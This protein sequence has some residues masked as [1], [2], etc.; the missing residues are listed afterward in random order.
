MLKIIIGKRILTLF[1]TIS[2]FVMHIYIV[3]ARNMINEII[4]QFCVDVLE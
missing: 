3:T 4:H 2:V 1:L